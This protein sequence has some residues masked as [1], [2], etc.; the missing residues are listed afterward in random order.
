[1]DDSRLGERVSA[2]ESSLTSLT[3][4]VDRLAVGIEQL[5]QSEIH[6]RKTPWPTLISAMMLVVVLVSAIGGAWISPLNVKIE[7][8]EAR[9]ER[10][11]DAYRQL[12]DKLQYPKR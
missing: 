1:M 10:L 4:H 6:N 3:K 5:V 2:L 11:A 12:F 9:V 7:N 8:T